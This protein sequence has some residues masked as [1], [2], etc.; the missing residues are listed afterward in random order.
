M[1]AARSPRDRST[2]T[3]VPAREGSDVARLRAR[4]REARRRQRTARID[5]GL[6][7]C[8]ALVL[9]LATPGLAITGLITLLILALCGASI[10]RE[11]RRRA[12]SEEETPRRGERSRTAVAASRSDRRASDPA[13]RDRARSTR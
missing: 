7:M 11:R 6:G 4:R 1:S 5:L 10:V 8:A 13:A 12:R 9:L 3:S 2:L